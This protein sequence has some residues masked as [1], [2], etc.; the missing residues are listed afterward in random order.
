MMV[1]TTD[2]SQTQDHLHREGIMKTKT[3]MGS[4]DAKGEWKGPEDGL[5]WGQSHKGYLQRKAKLS[6]QIFK[7]NLKTTIFLL[8]AIH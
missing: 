4:A 1:H 6:T 7:T 2:V 3:T 8:A 5:E